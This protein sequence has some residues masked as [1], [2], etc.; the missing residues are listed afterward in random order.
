MYTY[1]Y[2]YTYI[3][4]YVSIRTYIYR[5]LHVYIL[6]NTYIYRYIYIYFY[7]HKCIYIHLHTYRVKNKI[8]SCGL[9]GFCVPVCRRLRSLPNSAAASGVS[10]CRAAGVFAR[11][12]GVLIPTTSPYI[13]VFDRIYLLHACM[14]ACMRSRAK[15]LFFWICYFN[16]THVD[17]FM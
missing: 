2:M 12:R 14:H 16:S 7:I 4:T 10:V 13:R 15:W 5:Y 9:G 1:T 8:L 6:D 3:H 11:P 17:I